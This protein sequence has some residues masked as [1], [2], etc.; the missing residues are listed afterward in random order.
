MCELQISKESPPEHQ[1]EKHLEKSTEGSRRQ[2]AVV[3]EALRERSKKSDKTK[4]SNVRY[5][6]NVFVL[7]NLIILKM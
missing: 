1:K 2:I 6:N 3:L 4:S 7:A 5:H